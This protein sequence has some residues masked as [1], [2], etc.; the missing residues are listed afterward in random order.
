MKFC[1]NCGAKMQDEDVFCTNCG[2]KFP[3]QIMDDAKN[4]LANYIVGIVKNQLQLIQV[5]QEIKRSFIIINALLKRI[6]IY[7]V[8]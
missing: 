3:Q 8:N 1:T 7:H 6:S 2:S 5:Q 4:Y